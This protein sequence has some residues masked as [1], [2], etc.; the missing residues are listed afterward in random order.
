LPE[1][2]IVVMLPFRNV[3]LTGIVR[4]K[5]RRKMSK[6][7]GNSPDPLDLIR[8]FGA[9]GVRVGMLLSS[10]A[11]NDLLFDEGLVEQGRN[12]ANK[13]WN[14][15][16]LVMGW[17]THDNGAT[18]L[19]KLAISWMQSRI[20]EAN[21]VLDD[22][23]EK[24]R[25]SDAL[26]TLYKLIWD[27]FCSWYLEMVKPP[28]GEPIASETLAATH[29]LLEKLMKMLH[30]FMPFLTEE[31]YQ[32]MKD[33]DEKDFVCVSDMPRPA[34]A[35]TD[36][37]KRFTLAQ[38]MTTEGRKFRSQQGL[39]PKEKVEIFVKTADQSAFDGIMPVLEKFLNAD[40]SFTAEAVAG[41]GSFRVGTHELFVPAAAVDN[42]AERTKIQEDIEYQ[43]GFLNMVRKK[44][45]NERFVQN[46]PEQ[47]VAIER[48]KE[49]DALAKLEVLKEQLARLG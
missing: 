29:D 7:L 14:A 6:S 13:V 17:E 30:P 44:L 47:V 20:N 43:E 16:R 42:E 18:D 31:V 33:R 49:A 38:E 2:N 25:L 27:D 39:S 26:M 1:K 41:A 5:Q 3:Y 45:G 9:D 24:F 4:D 35:D 37:L 46:A 23:F 21:T 48:K 22:Q 15:F 10:P 34:A 19:D 12:Y 32:R 8:D 36:L 28:Y 11:G 40:I